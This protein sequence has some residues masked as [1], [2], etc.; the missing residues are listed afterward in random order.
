[1]AGSK[2]ARKKKRSKVITVT[3]LKGGVGKSTVTANLAFAL[4]QRGKRI[5]AI[6]FDF[7]IRNLDLFMGLEDSVVYDFGDAVRGTVPP[8]KAVVSNPRSP[9]LSLCAAPYSD[10]EIPSKE[11]FS[12]T[13]DA[14]ADSGLYDYIIIDTPGDA[15]P[16]LELAVSFSDMAIIV[17]T[18][19][20]ASLR[21]AEKTGSLVR[22]YG[23][24]TSALVINSFSY[25]E[26]REGYRPG[27]LSIIDRA[28]LPLLG[29]VPFSEAVQRY[30]EEGILIGQT[31]L[32]ECKSAFDNIA[33][34]ICGDDLPLFSGFSKSVKRN[35]IEAL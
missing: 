22:G 7:N 2:N 31:N 1:M 17:T 27:I 18:H 10:F 8:E 11:V 21:A 25:D 34:R 23:A 30:Q 32:R 15:G 24:K 20:P 3:S 6:D 35:Y 9:L 28:G 5:L 19:N 29:I 13:L 33:A 14:Y 12:K 4:S 16:V 26:T